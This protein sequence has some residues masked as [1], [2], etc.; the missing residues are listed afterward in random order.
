MADHYARVNRLGRYMVLMTYGA[1]E[2]LIPEDADMIVENTETGSTLKKNKLRIIDTLHESQGCL[3][4][5]AHSGLERAKGPLMDA[6]CE[7]F[8]SGV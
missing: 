2:A 6:I 7:L 1:T 3:I 8:L 5:N 4:A